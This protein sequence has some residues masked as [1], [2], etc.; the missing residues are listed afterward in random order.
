MHTKSYPF[1][2]GAATWVL[3]QIQCLQTRIV[4]LKGFV[5]DYRVNQPPL[6]E[7]Y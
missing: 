6:K 1:E 5:E 3:A 4:F 2:P 7:I